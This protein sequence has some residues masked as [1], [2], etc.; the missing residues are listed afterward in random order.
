MAER[1]FRKPSNPRLQSDAPEAERACMEKG[2]R[3]HC[4]NLPLEFEG[5]DA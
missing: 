5:D 1:A 3:N 2:V 4:L